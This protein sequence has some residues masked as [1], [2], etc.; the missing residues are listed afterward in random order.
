MCTVI[1]DVKKLHLFARTLD[2]EYSFDEQVVIVP[3]GF[4][5][6]FLREKIISNFIRR[7]L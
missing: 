2:L 3:R 4:E 1:S 6:E 5:L 7:P